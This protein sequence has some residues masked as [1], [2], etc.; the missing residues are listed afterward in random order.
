MPII[1]TSTDGSIYAPSVY[2]NAAWAAKRL[3][4]SIEVLHVL[5]HHREHSPMTDLTGAI[6]LDATAELTEELT[7]LEEAQGRV[8]RLKG[9][10]I[11]EDARRQLVDAGITN[12]TTTQRHGTLLETLE[13]FEPRAELVVVGK[14][15]VPAGSPNSSLGGHLEELVRISI[16]PVLV[17]KRVFKP[18]K[19]FLIAFDNSPSARKAVD[20]AVSSPLLKGLDCSLVMVGRND[21][22]HEA[23]LNKVQAQLKDAEF[24]VIVKRLPGSAAVV[25]AKEVKDTDADLL[26]MGAYGHSHIREFI[27]GSTTT[28]LVRSCS[29]P[30]LMFQSKLQH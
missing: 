6:G 3:S 5:D 11:L 19:K 14:G 27:V 16:R 22:P 26:V 24:N 13:E 28:K 23:T 1:L 12:V 17:A 21:A 15:G 2:K 7:K 4:A 29:A 10:A 9:Q 30:V 20:F 8:A 18:I 25:I